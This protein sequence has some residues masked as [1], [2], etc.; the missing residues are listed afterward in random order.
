MYE[1]DQNI[2]GLLGEYLAGEMSALRREELENWLNADERNRRFFERI[3]KDR[4]FG[5]RWKLRNSIDVECAIERFDRNTGRRFVKNRVGI[6]SGIAAACV[7]AIGFFLWNLYSAPEISSEEEVVY[8]ST[9][10]SKA[11]LVLAD[12]K[13]IDLVE[14]LVL[15]DSSCLQNVGNCLIYKNQQVFSKAYNE[16]QVPKGGEYKI[17][18]SDGTR[19]YMNSAS[20]LKYPI[21]FD[22]SVRRV[23]LSGEAFFEVKPSSIPFEVLLGDA[24]IRVYGTAF[25]V[26]MHREGKIETVLVNGKIGLKVRGEMQE[27]LLKPSQLAELDVQTQKVVV[28]NVDVFPYIAWTNGEYVFE[29][30]SLDEILSTL[31]LWYNVEVFFQKEDL[32][33]LHFTGILRRYAEIDII[34]KVLSQSVDVNIERNGRSVMVY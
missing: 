18:L 23:E 19:I 7:L 6:F 28:K 21:V 31:A 29:N 8:V 4:S 13:K 20:T 30:K 26:N 24:R 12:G 9:G 22:D 25:N 34:L 33:Q 17:E 27:Y 5:R 14:D 32:K 16:L 15:D 2:I 11:I 10:E 3:C 1:I